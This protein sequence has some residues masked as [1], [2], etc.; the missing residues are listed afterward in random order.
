MTI[1]SRLDAQSKSILVARFRIKKS[2]VIKVD[3]YKR[4][5]NSTN[6]QIHQSSVPQFLSSR[7]FDQRFLFLEITSRLVTLTCS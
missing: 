3:F 5:T 2:V 7:T 6:S 4:S 1:K